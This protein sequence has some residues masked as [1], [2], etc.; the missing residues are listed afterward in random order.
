MF[1]MNNTAIRHEVVNID[2]G[3][4]V[5]YLNWYSCV[6]ANEKSSERADIGPGCA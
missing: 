3:L 5:Y 6:L 4:H 1:D 2:T